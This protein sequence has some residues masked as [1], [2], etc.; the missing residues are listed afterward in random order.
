[1][2]KLKF[3]FLFAVPV[4]I[5][6]QVTKRFID[7]SLTLFSRITVIPGFFDIVKAYNTG[8]AFS[9]FANRSSPLVS[10]VFHALTFLAI[11][12]VVYLL[13]KIPPDKKLQLASLNLIIGGAMGNLYDR[14]TYGHVVDFLDFYIGRYHWPAFNVAD[15]SIVIGTGLL[16]FAILR[17][18][19]N[20]SV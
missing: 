15:S 1:M 2:V 12:F 18:E 16:L 20:D 10:L 17:E 5:V 11:L 4:V 7:H 9:L 8:A 6:D 19:K 14:F 3:F 13:V